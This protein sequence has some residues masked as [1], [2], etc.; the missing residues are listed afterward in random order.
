MNSSIDYM[1]RPKGATLKTAKKHKSGFSK[2]SLLIVKAGRFPVKGKCE[3]FMNFPKKRGAVVSSAD[4][5]ERRQEPKARA[6]GLG[7]ARDAAKP[8]AANRRSVT[9]RSAEPS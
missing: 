7:L 6:E 4:G 3:S 8:R 5:A 9:K 1:K 2:L